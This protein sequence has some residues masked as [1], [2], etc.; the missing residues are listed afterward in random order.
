M[1]VD[2]TYLNKAYPKDIYLLPN[3]DHLV[4]NAFGFGMLSFKDAFTRYN[5]LKM[6]L[7]DEDKIA[8]ITNKRVYCYRVMTF[9]PKN[10]RAT[11]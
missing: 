3:I 11:Y 6:H 2:F 10:V 4:D 7:D 1:C 9:D 8:F 5:Q